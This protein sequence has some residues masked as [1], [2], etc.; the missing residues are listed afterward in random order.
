[1]TVTFTEETAQETHER[2]MT[3]LSVSRI[4]LLMWGPTLGGTTLSWFDAESD[5]VT[6]VLDAVGTVEEYHL[7]PAPTGTYAFVDRTGLE[8]DPEV[9]SLVADARVVFLPPLTYLDTGELRFEA[10]G[11][12]SRL[13]RFFDELSTLVSV[14]LDR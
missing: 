14:R 11:E 4:D 1:M 6:H 7:V 10:V 3:A 9:L 5:A 2:L 13:G 12:R 8:F